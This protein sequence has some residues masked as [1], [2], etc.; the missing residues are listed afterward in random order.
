MTL[1]LVD[2]ALLF[3][4]DAIAVIGFVTGKDRNK[5]ERV[6]SVFVKHT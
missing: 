1:G 5:D 6:K 3:H 2:V 4:Y